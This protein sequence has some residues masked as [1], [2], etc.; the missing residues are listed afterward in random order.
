MTGSAAHLVAFPLV[1]SLSVLAGRATRLAG[2]EVA[3]LWPA[4]AVGVIWMLTVWDR[5][6]WERAAHVVLLAVVSF[7]TNLVTGASIPLSLW[8][9][10]VNVVLSVLTVQVLTAGR[11]EVTLRDPG[12]FAHL[13]AAVTA[14]TCSAA[15]LATGYFAIVGDAP[16]VETFALFAVR[17]GATALLGLSTWLT[18]RDRETHRRRLRA[19]F[20]IELLLVACGVAVL[21]FWTF[22]LNAAIPM[23]FIALLPAMWVALRYSTTV[24]TVFLLVA[25]VW[26]VYATLSDRG[27][28][29][30]DVQMRALL[31]QGMVCSLTLVVLT[32]SLYRDSRARLIAELEQARDRAD[33][34]ASHDSLTGLAN[35]DLFIERIED[36]LEQVRNGASDGV[37]LI[38]LDLDG[39]KAVNDTWGHAEGDEVLLEVSA[40]VKAAIETTDTAARLGGDEFAVLCPGTADIGRLEV[41][42]EQLREDLRQPITLGM[43]DTYDRLSVSAGVVTGHGECDAETLLRQADALMYHAKRSGKDSV[44]I[45]A[46]SGN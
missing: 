46:S 13:V 42:A 32:L 7:A 29:V 41:I 16:V 38:F 12:D 5:S 30:D 26:I 37:G 3:L 21:F 34:L 20:V 44:S 45:D 31:A 23:A 15:V 9:V 1:Y 4:A 6:N 19:K 28:V 35:R 40:R 8:F 11:D 39:F 14:G 36:A 17:N 22:W 43:G 33:H 24:S 27:F 18:L 2:G 10:L 25:G